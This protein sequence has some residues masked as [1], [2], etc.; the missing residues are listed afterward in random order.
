MAESIGFLEWLLSSGLISQDDFERVKE[1]LQSPDSENIVFRN[2]GEMLYWMRQKGL[3]DEK[4]LASINEQSREPTKQ[5]EHARCIVQDYDKA[6][7]E[8]DRFIIFWIKLGLSIGLGVPL[9]LVAVGFSWSYWKDS[10]PLTCDDTRVVDLISGSMKMKYISQ[11]I[12]RS[13]SEN[14]NTA[15]NFGVK[16][17]KELG[18]V[19]N[20]RATG[21]IGKLVTN[22]GAIDVA[23][24]VSRDDANFYVHPASE[25]YL[26][27]KYKRL[28]EDGVLP[29]YVS[30]AG[31]ADI[32][33][34]I[35]KEVDNFEVP[36]IQALVGNTND[37]VSAVRDILLK[38]D[39]SRQGDQW[40]C[41]VLFD[42]R[43]PMLAL[44]KG[45]GWN[46]VHA[47]LDFVRQGKSLIAAAAF[48][49]QLIKAVAVARIA[50]MKSKL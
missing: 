38:K 12:L 44:V 9:I 46:V 39:C 18:Y 40:T 5:G 16:V 49:E 10:R 22:D 29:V 21:C 2:D 47:K 31:V 13:G 4:I 42:Y 32:K 48:R 26:I 45:G 19:K 33:A 24:E 17:V 30:P 15:N 27:E 37:D 14:I 36:V 3:L 11:Q 20:E 34:V 8:A 7:S 35:L 25:E 43:D 1:A 23:Y 50:A 41:D 6:K 28:N